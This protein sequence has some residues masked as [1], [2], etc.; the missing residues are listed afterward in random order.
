M[1]VDRILC[2]TDYS[3]FSAQALDR[4]VGLA[5]WFGAEVEVLHVIPPRPWAIP[6]DP[7]IPMTMVPADLLRADR[8]REIEALDRFVS[9]HRGG[10]VP[11]VVRLRDGDPGREIAAAVLEEPADLL[12]MGTHGRSGFERFALGSVTEKVLRLAHCPVLTVGRPRPAG[13]GP[14]FQRIVCALDLTSASTRTLETALSLA[15]ENLARLT[16]L[17]VVDG[18]EKPRAG[19]PPPAWAEADLAEIQRRLHERV[20]S[21]APLVC[22][23]D[24]RIEEGVPWR[25]ILEVAE[26][27]EADLLVMGAHVG[28]ELD[29]ALFGSTVGRVVRRA[30]CPVLVVREARPAASR[31]ARAWAEGLVPMA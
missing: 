9:R 20:P 18:L 15:G 31:P 22:A 21:E 5:R 12:V 30:E 25:R 16:L 4:A 23:V 3:E 29:R 8:P 14:L 19:D 27:T 24:E 6:A 7:A 17:H 11:I 2:P 28:H 1:K 13:A 10:N 26:E